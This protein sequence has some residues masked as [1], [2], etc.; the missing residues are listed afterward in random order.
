[1]KT[2]MFESTA[3]RDTRA[4]AWVKRACLIV[5]SVYLVIGMIAACRALVQVRS[6][7]VQSPDVLRQG[8]EV[9][10][11]VVS[12]ARVPLDMHIEL[13]QDGHSEI[14]AV[15]RVP[16]NE[17]AL[18]DPRTR[19]SSVMTSLTPDVLKRFAEGKAIVRAT[20]IRRQQ[21]GRHPPPVVTERVVN[22][23]RD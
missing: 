12:Y 6:L 8:S 15:Q 4:I 16:N 2:A 7:E 1:M 17:W 11:T 23:D 14:I 22:I 18:L 13:V 5:V 3:I 20:V 19:E 9:S 21:L 10:A